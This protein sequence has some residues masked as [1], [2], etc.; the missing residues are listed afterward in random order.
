[1]AFAQFGLSKQ[2]LVG[3]DVYIFRLGCSCDGATLGAST[4]ENSILTF[5]PETLQP[6]RRLEGHAD[7]VTDLGFFQAASGG[8]ASCSYDGSARVWDLR[9]AE[10]CVRHFPVTSNEV[11]SCSVGRG[12]SALACAASEKVHLFDVGQGKRMRVYKDAH[13]DVV[14]H[15]RFHPVDTWKLLSGSEDNLVTVLD[16]N[17]PSQDEALLTVIPNEECVRSFTLVG[18]RRD[19][20]CCAS[21]TDDLRIWS[22]GEDDCGSKRAEFLGL[23]CH[24]LLMRDESFGYVVETFYD[25]PSEQVFLLA[26]AGS[27]GDL[28]LFRV[29]L[30]EP[31]PIATFRAS[32]PGEGHVGIVRSALCMPG[33]SIVT[34][35]EDG[36]LCAW[37]EDNAGAVSGQ[38]DDGGSGGAV[39]GAG[40]CRSGA[41]FDLEPTSYG[42]ARRGRNGGVGAALGDDRG[43][44]RAA[45]Y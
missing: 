27:D 13:T 25:Q 28:V 2:V 22:L 11:Y 26:G 12:D 36:R 3:N 42:A 17:E 37:R 15:V 10:A 32:M 1:M 24:P 43:A 29:A 39:G 18:P 14:N 8:L 40:S 44:E 38:T 21:T 35:G 16:T 4:S 34:A 9:A 41:R 7:A 20:L 6:V 19:T 30:P 45:P 33:G 23:R 31:L 5:D